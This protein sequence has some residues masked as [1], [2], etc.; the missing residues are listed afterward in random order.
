MSQARYR[1]AADEYLRL[2]TT[3]GQPRSDEYRIAAAAALVEGKDAPAA[4]QILAGLDVANLSDMLLLRHDVLL[5][6]LAL[7]ENEAERVL[8]L[9]PA[10]PNA[11]ADVETVRHVHWLRAL[12]FARLGDAVESVRE[13]VAL[14]VLLTDPEQSETNRRAIWETLSKADRTRLREMPINPPDT[15]SGWLELALTANAPGMNTEVFSRAAQ[16]WRR[17]YPGHPAGKQILTELLV[18]APSGPSSAWSAPSNVALLLPLDGPFAGAGATVR[19]GFMAAW[20]SDIDNPLRPRISVHDTANTNVLTIYDQAVA[21]GADFVVGPL[22]K[23][24]VNLVAGAPQLVVP[25]MALNYAETTTVIEGLGIGL[26]R[27]PVGEFYQFALSPED[28]AARV[29][30]RAAADG[31]TFAAVLAPDGEWGERVA[32]AFQGAW[33]QS[34]GIVVAEQTYPSDARDM[35]EPVKQ[36]LRINGSVARWRALKNVIKRDI[37]AQARRRRDMDFIFMA[38][39]PRQARQLRPQI[40][41]HHA[42]RVPVYSTSH[43]FAGTPD[44]LSDRDIDGVLFGDMP[45]VL[46]DTALDP[47]ISDQLGDQ[48][49]RGASGGGFSRLYAFGVDAYRLI[50]ALPNLRSGATAEIQGTTGRLSLDAGNRIQRQPVWARFREGLPEVV[51]KGIDS[52][53]PEPPA[54]PP[55][56]EPQ[57]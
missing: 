19:D 15:L 53:P 47:A 55:D 16:E 38:A 39:F 10:E 6:R 26:E 18:S 54:P 52:K 23:E 28:E 35:S 45:W 13:R 20:A 1:E 11:E 29:A 34:G 14:D 43:V 5:A 33:E 30:E 51:D 57:T 17:R 3:V 24:S 49:K 8:A 44:Q 42:E 48:I 32:A 50:S 46:G 9:L 2:A 41:F 27:G 40:M 7:R 12:A 21:Q 56:D 37:K 4:K 25:T 36:L 22:D 31:H